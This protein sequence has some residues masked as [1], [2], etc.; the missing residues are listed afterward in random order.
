[1]KE[2]KF[3]FDQLLPKEEICNQ[4]QLRRALTQNALEGGR[5][6]LYGRRNV[7]KTSILKNIVIPEFLEKGGKAVLFADLFGVRSRTELALRLKLAFQETLRGFVT[8]ESFAKGALSF[9]KLLKPSIEVDPYSAQMSISFSRSQETHT[10]HLE[11]V[12]EGIVSFAKSHKTLL[13]IDEFQDITFIEGAEGIMRRYFESMAQS[14]AIIV[15]GSKKHMLNKIFGTPANPLAG[16]G[17]DL[18]VDPIS[19]T[20]YTKYLQARFQGQGI[21]LPESVSLFFQNSLCRM[22]ESIN[23]VA[24]NIMLNKKNV[25]LNNEDITTS[26]LKSCTDRQS[27]FEEF[28]SRLLDSEKKVLIALSKCAEPVHQIQGKYFVGKTGLSPMGTQKAVQKLLDTAVLY[29]DSAALGLEFGDPLLKVYL[30]T[31]R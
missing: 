8:F 30:Q 26:I 13:V 7:G 15:S 6:V 3:I 14:T 23:I 9:L 17:K 22:P 2:Q 12:L 20:H 24:H 27:R 10:S 16:W 18:T 28:L 21:D 31:H 5:V 1:M 11:E 25:V 29:N 19:H 4:D